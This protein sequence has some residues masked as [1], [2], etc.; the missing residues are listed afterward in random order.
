MT[1]K[2]RS[3]DE[4]ESEFIPLDDHRE[5]VYSFDLG[6]ASALICAGYSLV[7]L[8]RGNLKKVQF[9]FRRTD[10]IDQVID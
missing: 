4:A 7:S 2:K 3:I 6:L 10:G 9:I 8:D 1:N 5:Y